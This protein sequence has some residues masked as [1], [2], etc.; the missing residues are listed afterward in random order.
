[1]SIADVSQKIIAH[2][3]TGP[4]AVPGQKQVNSLSPHMERYTSEAIRG[5]IIR[6]LQ[7]AVKEVDRELESLRAIMPE[8][9][10]RHIDLTKAR[11]NGILQQVYK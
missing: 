11:I 8:G 9:I 2:A 7:S 1:M 10:A 3:S 5:H 4:S 6:E